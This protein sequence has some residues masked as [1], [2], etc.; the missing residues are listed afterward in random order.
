MLEYPEIHTIVKQMKSE[1][2]GKT[3]DSGA[4]VKKSG[5]MFMSENDAS[6]YV[7]LNGG[8]VIDIDCLAPDIFIALDNGYGILFCQSGGKILYNKTA[9]DVPKSYNIC[10]DFTDGSCLTYTMNL[11]TLGIYAITCEEWKNR[12]VYNKK[13]EPLAESTFEDYLEFLDKNKE[14]EKTPVK[15]FLSGC[16]AGIMSTFAG[17]IL[18]YA[19]I[20]PSTQL[21]KLSVEQHRQMY[22]SIKQVL[23][24][25]CEKGGRTTECDLYNQ[26]GG[27]TAIAERKNIGK[28][29]PVCGYVLTKN[30]TGGVTAFCPVCQEK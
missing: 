3:V 17:E 26:K 23:T 13:F 6:K 27:Y 19:K 25:A 20:Y 9:S 15:L 4:W 5:N 24:L 14:Q 28:N 10:F 12:K 18:L 30:S 21:G 7:L 8:K 22:Q 29:C 1:L 11:F 2:M 16:I